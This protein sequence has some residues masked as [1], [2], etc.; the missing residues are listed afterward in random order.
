MVTKPVWNDC[1]T[2]MGDDARIEA[3]GSKNEARASRFY[4]RV[5]IPA[6]TTRTVNFNSTIVI[7][8]FKKD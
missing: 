5:S 7:Q 2:V 4:S 3:R 6:S 1:Q 8:G